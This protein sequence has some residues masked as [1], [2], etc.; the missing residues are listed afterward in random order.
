MNELINKKPSESMIS[1][2]QDFIKQGNLDSKLLIKNY[3]DMDGNIC[4][5]YG[6]EIL[7]DTYSRVYIKTNGVY[8]NGIILRIYESGGIQDKVGLIWEKFI[9][10]NNEGEIFDITDLYQNKS[11][12]SLNSENI[13]GKNLD[14]EILNTRVE[15]PNE[16][17][18]KNILFHIK[19]RTLNMK[20]K[21][22][23]SRTFNKILHEQTIKN[24]KTK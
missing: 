17:S 2:L 20:I 1:T 15:R 14:K 12:E 18:K 23:L 5:F 9:F 7:N 19:V 3:K 6:D 13:F 11:K 24:E 4:Y 10:T 21:K 16:L 22:V 8:E